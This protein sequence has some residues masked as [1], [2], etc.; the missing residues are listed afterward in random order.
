MEA[1]TNKVSNRITTKERKELRN[2]LTQLTIFTNKLSKS[3]NSAD[4]MVLV[5]V[6]THYSYQLTERVEHARIA[7]VTRFAEII[8]SKDVPVVFTADE[9]P[10]IFKYAED[11]ISRNSDYANAHPVG[12]KE[13]T[14]PINARNYYTTLEADQEV[15]PLL[16]DSTK[17]IL[18]VTNDNGWHE[19]SKDLTMEGAAI[20]GAMMG[21][22]LTRKAL[23]QY[24]DYNKDLVILLSDLLIG[25]DLTEQFYLNEYDLLHFLRIQEIELR[26][27]TIKED[28]RVLR[29]EVMARAVKA[30]RWLMT[31]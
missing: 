7:L 20:Y 30:M 14:N 26:D 9:T 29:L 28:L 17:E 12:D 16:D 3:I 22:V 18:G 2:L 8:A 27:I 19:L 31:K 13:F 5:E 10:S 21:F 1:K 6:Q 24:V 4:Q 11:I 25:D 15:L 23:V